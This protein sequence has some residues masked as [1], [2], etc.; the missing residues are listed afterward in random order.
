MIVR[1]VNRNPVFLMVEVSSDPA[2]ENDIQ[3]WEGYD[4]IK[5][6][7]CMPEI[8]IDYDKLSRIR[9]R[10]WDMNRHIYDENRLIQIDTHRPSDMGVERATH[11]QVEQSFK[12]WAI[13]HG[14]RD[15]IADSIPKSKEATTKCEDRT[16]FLKEKS[17]TVAKEKRINELLLLVD[18]LTKAQDQQ[19][20]KTSVKQPSPVILTTED[21]T[22]IGKKRSSSGSVIISPTIPSNVS[23]QPQYSPF[24]VLPPHSQ[25]YNQHTVDSSLAAFLQYYHGHPPLPVIQPPLQVYNQ[26]NVSTCSAPS[27]T[28]NTFSMHNQ[29]EAE[30]K[31]KDFEV[32]L[33]EKRLKGLELDIEAARKELAMRAIQQQNKVS[34]ARSDLE[35]QAIHNDKRELFQAARSRQQF[36]HDQDHAIRYQQ[37]SEDR[38][39]MKEAVRR[40]WHVEDR[41]TENNARRNHNR[42]IIEMAARANDSTTLQSL[43]N[44]Q[45]QLVGNQFPPTPLPLNHQPHFTPPIPPLPP[46][47]PSLPSFH[48]TA[49]SYQSSPSVIPPMPTPQLRPPQQ[50]SVPTGTTTVILQ[51][52]Q[53]GKSSTASA[54]YGIAVPAA[55]PPFRYHEEPPAT[56]V[57]DNTLFPEYQ[58]SNAQTAGERTSYDNMSSEQ[59]EEFLRRAQAQLESEFNAGNNTE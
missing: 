40:Q 24:Q 10:Y 25:V 55:V 21:R 8:S 3:R 19:K 33:K 34:Q 12:H 44:A 7:Y 54:M 45:R 58:S 47:P 16:A 5:N 41:A 11:A 43:L 2:V 30:L 17:E 38:L 1:C 36:L 48:S 57:D 42:D 4:Q 31:R 51:Q 14:P 37:I 28:S 15:V 13:R 46:P 20:A 49:V 53:G 27:I 35:M 59:I 22:T 29:W 6:F 56:P 18:K 26:R 32:T 23:E 50:F 52:D 39:F 9:L